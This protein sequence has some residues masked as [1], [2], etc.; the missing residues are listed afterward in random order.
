[1][2][3]CKKVGNII[4]SFD[5]NEFSIML[6]DERDSTKRVHLL[7][8]S[9]ENKTLSISDVQFTQSLLEE[10]HA[11]LEELKYDSAG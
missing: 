1:M 9:H 11:V 3:R 8:A 2:V 4:Y 7:S 6:M 10:A 5:G